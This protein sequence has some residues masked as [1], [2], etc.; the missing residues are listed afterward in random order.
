MCAKAPTP[1]T[2]SLPTAVALPPC[3]AFPLLSP[4][5]PR[6]P[7]SKICFGFKTLTARVLPGRRSKPPPVLILLLPSHVVLRLVVGW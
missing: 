7:D 4:I 3:G 5:V 6:E 1:P 2:S